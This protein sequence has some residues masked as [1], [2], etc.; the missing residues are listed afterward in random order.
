MEAFF[1]HGALLRT[2]CERKSAAAYGTGFAAGEK[3]SVYSVAAIRPSI[4]TG[5]SD[6]RVVNTVLLKAAETGLKNAKDEGADRS[7]VTAAMIAA[8]VLLA[9]AG[10]A[11]PLALRKKRKAL[12]EAVKHEARHIDDELHALLPAVKQVRALHLKGR[13]GFDICPENIAVSRRGAVLRVA[14]LGPK[15]DGTMALRPGFSAI[16]RYTGGPV[17]PWTDIYAVSALVYNALMGRPVPHAFERG[18]QLPLFDGLDVKYN[19]LA[20]V[21]EKGIAA[22][23][24][25]RPQSLDALISAIQACLAGNG[26]MSGKPARPSGKRGEETP[27]KDERKPP[28]LWK[29]MT[30]LCAAAVLL[31]GGA[32]AVCE[33]NYSQA[34]FCVETGDYAKAKASLGGVFAFYKDAA[35]LKR[36]AD[37]GGSLQNGDYETAL[38]GF[39]A[40]GGYRD[41]ADMA[42]ETK[43]R[44]ACRFMERRCFTKAQALLEKLGSY[45]DA[46]SL[47]RRAS[48]ENGCTYRNAGLFVSALEAFEKAEGYADAA[49]LAEEMRSA[50]YD[51]AVGALNG[52]DLDTAE[53]FFAAA[54]GYKRTDAY[55]KLIGLLRRAL[56]GGAF[57]YGDYQTLIGFADTVDVT[58]YLTSDALIGCYLRGSWRDDGGRMFDMDDDGG[59]SFSLPGKAS[60]GYT[61]SKGVLTMGGAPVFRFE[62][63]DVD[64]VDVYA[65]ENGETYRL[66]RRQ[67]QKI[68][69]I[70]HD[71]PKRAMS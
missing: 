37:A 61:L 11:L 5:G 31:F 60:D 9:A 56:S 63:M 23:I 36:Y 57:S 25:E 14:E 62:C 2:A 40:L 67:R 45:K 21:V 27:G 32:A 4:N 10:M 68:Q 51:A 59:I 42:A 66:T 52:G 24:S 47:L 3:G 12:T 20:G 1:T 38:S 13:Y 50:L 49:A 55:L 34:V 58:P 69:F 28:A 44:Q 48:Y 22:E 15:A 6:I 54:S 18:A 53:R 29:R 43:Y 70:N 71:I 30:M 19:A 46:A 41:A 17:G 35:K 8:G 7:A 39:E 26:A 65:Y 16:E 64:T 33:I